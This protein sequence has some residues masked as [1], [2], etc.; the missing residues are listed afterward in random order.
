MFLEV[1][2]ST[3][4]EITDVGFIYTTPGGSTNFALE[5]PPHEPGDAVF[6]WVRSSTGVPALPTIRD[7]SLS[8]VGTMTLLDQRSQSFGNGMCLAWYI[9]TIGDGAFVYSSASADQMGIH[10]YRGP[11][12]VGD[13]A[14]VSDVFDGVNAD[15]P[16]LNLTVADGSSRVFCGVVF[17]QLHTVVSTPSGLAKRLTS[18][19]A[20]GGGTGVSYDSAGVN[21]FST[22]TVNGDASSLH[23]AWA[24][25]MVL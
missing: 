11:S 7:A 3:A 13:A 14:F 5:I 21:S 24:V 18:P 17:N 8:V 1:A 12:A 23:Y 10:V 20:L 16:G 9:D 15:I 22:T 2:G 25:E 6:A 19:S 4:A